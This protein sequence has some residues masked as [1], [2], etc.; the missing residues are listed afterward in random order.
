MLESSAPGNG[1]LPLEVS[2]LRLELEGQP[3]IKGI[4]LT[5]SSRGVSVVMGY[6]GAGKSLLLRLLH[7]LVPPSSG[8]ITWGGEPISHAVRHRQA[9][10]FQSPVL[11]R[12]STAANV[13]FA[14]KVHGTPDPGRRDELLALVGL[15]H[16]AARPARLLSGGEQQRLALARALSCAPAVLLLDEP[17][18][19]LDPASVALFEDILQKAS[20]DGVKIIFVTHDLGQAKRLGEE[21]V[22]LHNGQLAEQTEAAGFFTRPSSKVAQA[23]LNGDLVF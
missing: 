14:L 13:D 7:G 23:Y 22:F 6:N 8:T 5:L 1:L 17:T 4:D 15:L 9:M 2:N 19:N 18:A 11:L 20:R 3:L 10:V 21:I 12:R 16:V